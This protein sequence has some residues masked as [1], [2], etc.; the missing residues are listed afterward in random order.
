[1]PDI[2]LDYHRLKT[3]IDHPDQSVTR[4]KLEYPTVNVSFA[5]LDAINKLVAVPAPDWNLIGSA[6]LDSFTDKALEGLASDRSMLLCLRTDKTWDNRYTSAVDTSRSTADLWLHKVVNKDVIDLANEAV[7]LTSSSSHLCKISASGST[8]KGFR[9]D[10]TTPKLTATDTELASGSVQIGSGWGKTT[11]YSLTYYLRTPAS[12][13]PPA[14]GVLEVNIEGSGKPEDPFRPLMSKN[15]AEITGLTGLPDFLYRE[16]RKYE[17]LKA[18]GFTDD[19]IITLFGGIIQTHVDLDSVTWGAFELHPDKSPTVIVT[20][21]GD[22]PYK[23]GAIER[24]KAKA[25]RVFKVPKDY[26]EAVSLYNQLKKDYPHRL[27]GVHNWCYQIFG[28]EFFDWLQNVDFYYGELIE[29]RTHYD[30]LKQVPDWEVRNR[31]NELINGLSKVTV[32]VEERDKHINKAREILK[33]GW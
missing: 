14:L 33:K 7:D 6:T 17:I 32:L 11:A 25:K 24:Q 19:E 8:I 16:A 20:I 4:A 10:M 26:S 2:V 31:L 1:M 3:P 28:L 5:Y 22:N 23:A 13:S 21:V 27:A 12:P 29:H 30:Q 9:A 15:L 18:K